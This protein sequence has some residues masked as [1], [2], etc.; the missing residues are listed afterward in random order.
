MLLDEG[1][2]VQI[3]QIEKGKDEVQKSRMINVFQSPF[4]EHTLVVS[5]K[6]NL[7][8]ARSAD[9]NDEEVRRQVQGV[10]SDA[11]TEYIDIVIK[12]VIQPTFA[13]YINQR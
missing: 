13:K 5:A 6:D 3:H 11:A 10:L 7:I 4:L 2:F 8:T 12:H 1:A 9:I